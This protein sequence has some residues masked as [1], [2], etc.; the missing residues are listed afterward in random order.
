MKSQ[1]RTTW[2]GRFVRGRRPDHNPLRRFTDRVETLV[3]AL[4]VFG[5]IAA[6][7]FAARGAGGW[8]YAVAHHDQLAQQAAS[9]QVTATLLTAVPAQRANG[10]QW[11]S[12]SEALATWTAPG[13]KVVTGEVPAA[14]G[15][16]AGATVRV[17]SDRAG[18]LTN[19]PLRAAQVTQ[20]AA[21]GAIA[22]VIALAV[23]LAVAGLVARRALDRRRLAGWD[24]DWR[25][26]GPRWTHHRA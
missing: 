26:T 13:G 1:P 18:Q 15:T 25:V 19:P 14:A 10:A 6:A 24:A 16:R 20:L 4:L 5:F 7:P 9:R 12:T 11:A 17:W 2:L 23:A 21:L 8:A 3:L 22:G